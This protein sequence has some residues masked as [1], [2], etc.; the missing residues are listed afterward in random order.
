LTIRA[1]LAAATALIAATVAWAHPPTQAVAYV[2]VARGGSV[3]VTLAFDPVALLVGK[4][5][6]EVTDT[7]I[8][9]LL[10]RPRTT[11]DSS[12]RALQLVLLTSIA[13][14][15]GDERLVATC[16]SFPSTEELI[17]WRARHREKPTAATMALRLHAQLPPDA[18][19]LGIQLPDAL[20]ASLFA[21]D[22][23][24]LERAVLP[25]D[26]GLESPGMDVAM[27]WAPGAGQDAAPGATPAAGT[28]TPAA[29]AADA[30]PHDPGTLSTLW[31]YVFLGFRH[32]VP[33]GTDHALFVLGLFLLSPRVLPLA[34]QVTA[35]TAAHTLTLTLAVLGWVRV[36]AGIV[37]PAIALSIA[38]IAIENLF[39]RRVGPWRLAVV[40]LFGLLHGLGFASGLAELGLPAGQLATGIG[41]FAVGV[42]AGHLAVIAGAFLLLGWTRSRPWYRARVE[43]PCS[44]AI[45]AVACWWTVARIA[46]G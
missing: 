26:A 22:R 11:L 34:K 46:A 17:D 4:P 3:D 1:A 18:R 39:A 43:I 42:E 10:S 44:L 7:E 19:T 14:R 24:G 32:I 45:A 33:E 5:S 40:F 12:L 29:R 31:R 27:A 6:A 21:L 2:A 28:P 35:F 25:L 9:A 16:T 23:P 37:E 41:G 15:T 36:P 30:T 20:G 38:F 8:D 13:L